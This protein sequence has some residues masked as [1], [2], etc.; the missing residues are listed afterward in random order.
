MTYLLVR[1]YKDGSKWYTL[2]TE[3]RIVKLHS[4]C[5]G[6]A[7]TDEIYKVNELIKF[8]KIIQDY[9]YIDNFP[10]GEVVRMCCEEYEESNKKDFEFIKKLL[11]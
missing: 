1:T 2:G 10:D 5:N 11:E 6:N 3:K 7:Y 9:C 4:Y 8:K